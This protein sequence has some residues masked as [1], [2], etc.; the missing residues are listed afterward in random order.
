MGWNIKCTKACMQL[1][2]CL[3]YCFFLPYVS[4]LVKWHA[5]PN[6]NEC[7]ACF[8]PSCVL[9]GINWQGLAIPAR[10]IY[11]YNCEQRKTYHILATNFRILSL[12][13]LDFFPKSAFSAKGLYVLFQLNRPRQLKY[14]QIFFYS[15]NQSLYSFNMIGPAQSGIVSNIES[16]LYQ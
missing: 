11:I 5:I 14:K 15:S 4:V 13:Y 3:L 1:K 10:P 9:P 12:V 8:L 16:A 7:L 6:A 2:F